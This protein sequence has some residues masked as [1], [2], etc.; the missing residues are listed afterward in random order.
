MLNV[1]T[2]IVLG[3]AIVVYSISIFLKNSKGN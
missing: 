3:I 1:L 2:G